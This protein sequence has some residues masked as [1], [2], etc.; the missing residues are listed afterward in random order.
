VSLG[1]TAAQRKIGYQMTAALP[2]N[3]PTG[4][5]Y[6]GLIV[7]TGQSISELDE[8]NNKLVVPVTVQP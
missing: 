6:L 7:D 4:A 2:N 1:W 5:Y 8:A 3:L